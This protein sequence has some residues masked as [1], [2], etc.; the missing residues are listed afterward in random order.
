MTGLGQARAYKSS[1]AG[2]IS[3]SDPSRRASNFAGRSMKRTLQRREQTPDGNWCRGTTEEPTPCSV[4]EGQG[5][6]GETGGPRSSSR[7][8]GDGT[9]GRSTNPKQGRSRGQPRAGCRA[10]TRGITSEPGKAA[11]VSETGGS[12]RSS[13]EERDNTTRSEPRTRGLW[14]SPRRPEA[15]WSENP[16]RRAGGP[17]SDEGTIKLGGRWRYVDLVLNFTCT[18]GQGRAERKTPRLEAGLGRTQCPEF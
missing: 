15:G 17:K 13:K 1:A 11:G 8:R 3:R 7:R 6:R 12:G 4:E 16:T 14:W 18:L 2:G 10:K 5:Q 9:C